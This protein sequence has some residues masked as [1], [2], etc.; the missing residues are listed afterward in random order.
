MN[1]QIVNN[2]WVQVK[3]IWGLLSLSLQC[4]WRS[5]TLKSIISSKGEYCGPRYSN[6][7]EN[8][9]KGHQYLEDITGPKLMQDGVAN[10]NHNH[11]R[12]TSGV[13]ML[14]TNRQLPQMQADKQTPEFPHQILTDNARS[15]HLRSD[16]N[17][18]RK[19]KRRDTPQLMLWVWNNHHPKSWQKA[20]WERKIP[21]QA[22][23]R[24]TE[25]KKIQKDGVSP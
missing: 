23:I 19:L 2:R 14:L 24:D 3:D 17:S 1:W 8:V 13:K 15:E 25:A 10:L 18:W 16:T 11:D 9:E 20:V 5:E 6:S 7:L 22:H 21:C 4:L 12:N